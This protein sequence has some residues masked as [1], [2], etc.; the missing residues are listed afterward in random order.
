MRLE[1][2]HEL[3]VIFSQPNAQSFASNMFMSG[4]DGQIESVAGRF[5]L[6]AAAGELAIEMQ[7]LPL[8]A[9]RG[10]EGLPQVAFVRGS[11]CA[12]IPVQVRTRWHSPYSRFHHSSIETRVFSRINDDF[13][14]VRDR[15][16]WTKQGSNGDDYL[17]QK[18]QWD[19]VV[20]KGTSLDP[21]A[22]WPPLNKRDLLKTTGGRMTAK[23]KVG[24]NNLWVVHV[25]SD[26]FGGN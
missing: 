15:V 23:Q 10:R 2:E 19:N 20:F 1:R 11:L 22:C 13:A 16:G 17:F 12:D 5:S 9:G 25:L 24:K 6:I 8:E 4:A 3:F 7:V 14:S 21:S 26:I 18:D